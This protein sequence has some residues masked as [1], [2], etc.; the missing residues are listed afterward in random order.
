MNYSGN[1]YCSNELF[2][3]FL[4]IHIILVT[5]TDFKVVQFFNNCERNYVQPVLIECYEIIFPY[6][7]YLWCFSVILFAL[8][9]L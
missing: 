9:Y 6:R 1:F 4:H 3:F 2:V 8:V 7:T 5:Q